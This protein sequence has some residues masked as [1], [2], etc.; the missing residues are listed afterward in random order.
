MR[1]IRLTGQTE[2]AHNGVI[3]NKGETKR[4]KTMNRNTS[5]LGTPLPQC[6]GSGTPG[7][8]I[9]DLCPECHNSYRTTKQGT[10]RS[11]VSKW[12][13]MN[14]DSAEGHAAARQLLDELSAKYNLEVKA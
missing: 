12:E 11:H 3:A 1:G 14:T 5:R 13:R 4:G 2:Y 8:G 6:P 10:I 7:I 9:W